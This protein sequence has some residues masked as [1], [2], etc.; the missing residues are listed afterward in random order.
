MKS[1]LCVERQKSHFHSVKQ[2]VSGGTLRRPRVYLYQV[3][4][5]FIMSFTLY[6]WQCE[7]MLIVFKKKHSSFVISTYP[8]P[9]VLTHE[10]NPKSILFFSS[11]FYIHHSRGCHVDISCAFTKMAG[12]RLCQGGR[13][14]ERH[15]LSE[16]LKANFTSQ[17]HLITCPGQPKA[18][19][20]MA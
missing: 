2:L 20:F 16:H 1:W 15:I 18:A 5:F 7:L 6:V 8:K 11:K 17:S 12:L 14:S 3:V 10:H 9:L 13:F 4:I 19:D